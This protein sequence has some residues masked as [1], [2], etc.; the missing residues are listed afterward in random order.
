MRA[1]IAARKEGEA[2]IAESGL[3]A[4][5]VRPW[6]VL[7]PGHRWPYLLVPVYK[8]LEVLPRTREQARRLGLVKL[9]QMVAA[10]VQ[11]VEHPVEGVKIIGAPEIRTARLDSGGMIPPRYGQS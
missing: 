11:A 6:Y 4:T 5:I 3:S 10:L 2:C 1:Y 8:L 7:G 9:S